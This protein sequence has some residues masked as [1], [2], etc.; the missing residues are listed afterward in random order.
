MNWIWKSALV[1]G[2]GVLVYGVLTPDLGIG[3]DAAPKAQ[4][5]N[6]AFQLVTAI[7]AF[8]TEYGRL[9]EAK[10]EC[11]PADA[12]LMAI[13]R[14]KDQQQNPRKIVFLEVP[15]ARKTDGRW[16]SGLHLE[17]GAWVDPFGSPYLVKLDI[18][19]DNFIPNPYSDS[20]AG[21][22]K[23][24]ESVIVW[25]SGKDGIFGNAQ[26]RAE[27]QGSDDIVSWDITTHNPR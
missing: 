9:P 2:L 16:R 3:P 17:T 13:L 6:D 15:D 8:Y 25:C 7:K 20:F 10:G 22:Q 1:A 5:K 26:R 21:P 4:A 18:D 23:I 27:L 24:S 11:V 14:G 12:A 19:Y